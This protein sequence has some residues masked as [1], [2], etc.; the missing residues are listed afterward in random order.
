MKSTAKAI[1]YARHHGGYLVLTAEARKRLAAGSIVDP[2]DP[3][4]WV[5]VRAARA[6]SATPVQRLPC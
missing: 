1:D 4:C 2:N 5:V 3:T 6:A